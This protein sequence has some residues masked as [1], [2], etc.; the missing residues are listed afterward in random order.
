[1]NALVRCGLAGHPT[2]MTGCDFVADVCVYDPNS[3]FRPIA[4]VHIN[5]HLQQSN[6]RVRPEAVI[7]SQIT[8]DKKHSAA[9]LFIVRVNLPC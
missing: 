4:E 2:R 5:Q 6:S 8:G 3:C 7:T 1:M 9:A